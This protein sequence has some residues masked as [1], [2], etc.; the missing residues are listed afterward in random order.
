MTRG[1]LIS[2]T[3]EVHRFTC[4]MAVLVQKKGT[5]E[6]G[7]RLGRLAIYTAS[8]VTFCFVYFGVQVGEYSLMDC[9][10][11]VVPR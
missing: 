9:I 7:V 8:R 2:E 10:A 5:T 6:F 1:F 3:S 4:Q 11:V